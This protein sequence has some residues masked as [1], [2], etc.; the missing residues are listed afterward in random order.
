[1]AVYN[2]VEGWQNYQFWGNGEFA[3]NFG[4]YEVNITVPEDHIMEATGEL[5]N[6]KDV[7]SR[8]E[9]Q[10]YKK[11]LNTFDEPVLIVT[12]E[13][14]EAKEATKATK[15]STWK[16]VAENVRDFGFATSRRFIWDMMAVKS[17]KSKCNSCFSLS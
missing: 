9:F 13:E 3:L 6:P 4:N 15:K 10:R 2:D 8:T 17:G 16:F 11:A 5:Q 1:M 12:Q 14:A 7:L